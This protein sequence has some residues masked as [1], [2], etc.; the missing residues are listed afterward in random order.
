MPAASPDKPFWDQ[1]E[2]EAL[3]AAA[4]IDAATTPLEKAAAMASGHEVKRRIDAVMVVRQAHR[5][6]KLAKGAWL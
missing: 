5:N 4:R 1:I 6:P 3:Q 2:R